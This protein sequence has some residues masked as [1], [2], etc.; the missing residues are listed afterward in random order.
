MNEYIFHSKED[1]ISKLHSLMKD[2][3]YI[4]KFVDTDQW[5]YITNRE[6]KEV[7]TFITIPDYYLK[8]EVVIS[9]NKENLDKLKEEVQ[10]KRLLSKVKDKHGIL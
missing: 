5:T 10:Q 3:R 7:Y 4:Y 2:F 9:H 6:T 1:L 8:E